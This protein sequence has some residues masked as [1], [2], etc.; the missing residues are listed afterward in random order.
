M[1]GTFT[2][3]TEVVTGE[4]QGSLYAI[5]VPP[6]WNGDLVLYAHGWI[7][8]DAPIALPPV[9]GF[10]DLVLDDG[11]AI[12]YSSYSEN[13]WAVRQGFK[14]TEHLLPLFRSHFG[15][16]DRVYV[17][18]QSM[19]GLI[20]VMLAEKH[21][22]KY[23]G[24][25]PICGVIGGAV[26]AGDYVTDVRILF[27]AYFPDVLPESALDIPDGIDVLNEVVLPVYGAVFSEPAKAIEMSYVTEL[28]LYWN[29]VFELADSTVNGVW[30]NVSAT[31]DIKDRCGG[32]FFDN[33]EGYT[34]SLPPPYIL[35]EGTL[36]EAVEH[37]TIDKKCFAYLKNWYEPDGKLQIPVFSLHESR[38]PAAPIKHEW[39]YASRVAA[40]G[41]SDLLVQRTK[42]AFGH[43]ENFTDEEWKA[44]FDEL[45]LWV[46]QGVKP[47]P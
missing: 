44:A 46:E 20:S 30:F 9:D 22:G 29:D 25:L 28:G 8:P 17:T 24:A 31:E 2:L 41:R 40:Q 6:S 32:V 15:P 47:L 13:G 7:H 5:Y 43:C 16:P 21:P 37:Y 26:M 35:D 10:R 11:F 14:E 19:G 45:V 12:A 3:D 36:N 33:T 34:H 1:P 39:E 18:G 27:D 23:D 4:W 42:D 38:D